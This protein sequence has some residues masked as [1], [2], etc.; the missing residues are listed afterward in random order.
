MSVLRRVAWVPVALVLVVGCSSDPPVEP[1]GSPSPATSASDPR[2]WPAV[3]DAALPAEQV[4]GLQ[5][6]IDG[7]VSSGLMSGV[8]AAV[9]TPQGAWAGAAGADG[10][11]TRLVPTS[12]M[13]LASITKTFTAAEVMLLAEQGKVDLDAPASTYLDI[14]QVANGVTVRQLLAQR[15]SVG[16]GRDATLGDPDSAW[17]PDRY[18]DLV[19]PATDPPGDTYR[20]DNTNFVL[21]GRIV[22]VAGGRSIDEAMA[23]DLWRP[24]GLARLSAQR[25]DG[26]PPPLAIA[27]APDTGQA[28][29]DRCSGPGPYLPCRAVSTYL[30]AAGG[31]AGDAETV[32]RWGYALYGA[33]VLSPE[34]V[35]QMTDFS[36]GDGYGLGTMDLAA[37]EGGRRGLQGVG[38]LGDAIVYRTVLAV[39]PDRKASVAILVPAPVEV[40]PFVRRFLV[41]GGLADP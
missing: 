35:A 1:T 33:Q 9:V 11:G 29:L 36:D 30:G 38:H 2:V 13:A 22:E 12:G 7:W 37:V 27:P 21:L 15:S 16:L 6:E 34:S 31:M 23:A 5:R 40:T 4:T 17:T 14:P 19:R 8:T 41:A 18:L 3:P 28:D 24:A 10:R 32:A 26:L 25:T 39:L 20:Y